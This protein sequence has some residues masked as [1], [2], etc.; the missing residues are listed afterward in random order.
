MCPLLR[1]ICL[2]T[3]CLAGVVQAATPASPSAMAPRVPAA[4]L[5]ADVDILEQAYTQLHPGLYRYNT[6]AQM[7]GHFRDLRRAL[8]HDQPLADAYLAFSR[9]AATIKCGHSYANFYNQPKA[10]QR[11]LFEQP[12]RVPF[13]F[14]WLD[15]R[16]IVT[17]NF[18]SD[19]SLVPGTEVM[20]I[21][22][23]PV[24]TILAKLK[25]IARADGSNDAKR[26]AYLEVQGNDAYEAFDIFL[27]LFFPQVGETLSLRVRSI[28]GQPRTLA[29]PALTYAQ[30]LAARVTPDGKA[31]SPAWTVRYRED[32]IAVL[33]MPTWGLYDSQWNWR[34]FLDDLFVQLAARKT[35]ALVIDLRRNE[36]G[37]S[38]GND[39]IAHLID[40]PLVLPQYRRLV[41][42][43]K[44]P[45]ALAPYLDTWD[46][47]FKD[48]GDQVQPRD[49]GFYVLH[50]YD[51]GPGGDIIAPKAPR[52]AGQVFVL[53]GAIN[54]SAT[55]EFAWQ[56]QQNHLATLVGQPTG[57]NQRG[58]NG[59]AFFFLRLPKSGIELDL[60]V[61]GQFSDAAHPD[62]GITPEVSVTPTAENIAQAQDPE[63]AA[64]LRAANVVPPH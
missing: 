52:Y 18:S 40:A 36:G 12:N 47:S 16:M 62:A 6:P 31:D 32:G 55:F 11:A 57:G 45:D 56:V 43:R 41:R 46:P 26:V 23:I 5:Q 19:A 38:I 9:F 48:W 63:L 33:D 24:A 10:I 42:Y 53:V 8:D 64:A 49:D 1:L 61:I 50:R 59:G 28:K 2:T 39:L 54:S 4:D 44:V 34:G 15:G 60:P 14:R 3:L 20:A 17:R 27:P 22:G 35:P 58:I 21:D 25:T 7:T 37:Q 30:R 13:Q 29:L 51:D